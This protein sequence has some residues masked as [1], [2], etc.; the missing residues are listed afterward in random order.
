MNSTRVFN[1]IDAIL[2]FEL[3]RDYNVQK[4]IF[5]NHRLQGALLRKY[6]IKSDV[7]DV[8]TYSF[9]SERVNLSLYVNNPLPAREL[10]LVTEY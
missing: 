7:S 3:T 8:V 6:V 2:Y 4:L 5:V 9:L 10:I 1:Y